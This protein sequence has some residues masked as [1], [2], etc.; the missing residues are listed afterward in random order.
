MDVVRDIENIYLNE[1]NDDLI[2]ASYNTKVVCAYLFYHY[3]NA[4]TALLSEISDSLLMPMRNDSFMIRAIVPSNTVDDGVDFILSID[5]KS[6]YELSIEELCKKLKEMAKHVGGVIYQDSNFASR[7]ELQ[8]FDNLEIKVKDST[9]LTIRAICCFPVDV[10]YAIDIQQKV[11]SIDVK[12]GNVVF[13]IIFQDN[14]EEE[15]SD[16]ECP[17]ECVSSGVL[18][19]MTDSQCKFGEESSFITLIS[20]KSLKQNFFQ[21]STR[22][23]FASNLRFYVTSK[24]ID[25]KIVDTIRNEPENFCYFNNG[26]IITCD[27]YSIKNGMLYLKNYS[28]VNGGQTT[29]LIGRTAFEEDF[30]VVCKIIKNKYSD[31]FSRLSF[32]SKVAEA[33][34]TQK[35][36][37]ARDLIANRIEQRKLKIQFAEA[38]M[39]LKIKRGEKIIKQQYPEPYMNASNDEVTQMLYAYVYQTPGTS[40]NSKSSLL[41]NERIYNLIFGNSY[42]TNFFVSIQRL[43]IAFSDWQKHIKK[44]ETHS[45]NKY[46]LSKHCNYI[47]YGLIGFILKVITNES[48]KIQI[49]KLRNISWKSDELK[50]LIRCNDIGLFSIIRPERFSQITKQ[51][52]FPL[53]NYLMDNI[54][55][56]AYHG[57]KDNY[58][59]YAFAQFC[60]TDS[61]YYDYVLP[62]AHNALLKKQNDITMQFI[63]YFAI[64][65]SVNVKPDPEKIDM[66][67][68]GLEDELKA[69]RTKMQ[70]MYPKSQG[71]ATIK[72]TQIALIVRYYPK[73]I[74]DLMSKADFSEDQAKLF[75]QDILDIVK[76]YIK[77]G[78]FE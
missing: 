39:F 47:L 33:S 70:K 51:T 73:T 20:A 2:N 72:A 3:F 40:K 25:G 60:R 22:G 74:S 10:N 48:V 11:A 66:V 37:N 19:L 30:A 6:F 7:D 34:N 52:F 13:D 49:L 9:T 53:F 68:L 27:D 36:I 76:K 69:Y 61:Y 28:V 5:E 55:L 12:S 17:K 31:E 4:D 78:D 16:I 18:K 50:N 58:P 24:K 23:L 64:D 41:S 65:T 59:T 56:P 8:A 32:L 35:P 26:V 46:G 57:F 62:Y 75:G 71:Y 1:N 67:L 21:Y 45:S 43:K 29:N 77:T 38:G 44:T 42:D 14:L 54:L 63:D 15:I